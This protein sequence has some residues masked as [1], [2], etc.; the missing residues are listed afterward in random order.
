MHHPAKHLHHIV[1][2]GRARVFAGYSVGRFGR[3]EAG[4]GRHKGVSAVGAKVAVLFCRR[5][6]VYCANTKDSYSPAREA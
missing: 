4:E 5:L 1:V 6:L 2:P 3:R